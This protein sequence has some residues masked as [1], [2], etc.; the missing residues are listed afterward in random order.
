MILATA[1]PEVTEL[2]PSWGTGK[3]NATVLWLD[4]LSTAAVSQLL[5][6]KLPVLKAYL[7]RFRR[8]VQRY[9]PV[10]AGSP[11]QAFRPYAERYPT[12][13]LRER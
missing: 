6:E 4:P 3:R 12:F 5:E 10:P 1:R 9:F 8:E 7:D 2:R 11:A 13:E